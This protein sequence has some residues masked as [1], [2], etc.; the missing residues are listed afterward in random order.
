MDLTDIK[1]SFEQFRDKPFRPFQEESIKWLLGSDKRFTILEAPTGSGKTLIAMAAGVANGSLTYMVH[2]KVL[3]NQVTEDFPEARSLF[4]RA[5]YSCTMDAE[6]SC[7]EC[8]HS[9]H[10]PCEYKYTCPYEVQKRVVLGARLKILNYDYFLSE[11]NY[12]GRFRDAN[13]L[14]IDEADNL[15]N[16]LINFCTLTFSQ[17]AIN[18]LG[19][20]EPAR[21]TAKSKEGIEPWRDFAQTAKYRVVSI[22]NKLD[23]EIKDMGEIKG[24]FRIKKVKERTRVKRLLEKIDLFL[25][26]VDE[27]WIFDDRGESDT[28]NTNY[29]TKYMP[30]QNYVFR[31]LWLNEDLAEEFLWKHG[32]KWVL[33]S[34][35]FLPQH[36]LTKTLGIPPNEVDYQCTPSTFP[37]ERRPIHIEPVANLTS[38]TMDAELPA[39]VQRIKEI[40]DSHPQ[41]KGLIHAV[42]YKLANQI[43]NGVQN[44]RLTTHNSSD[45]QAKLDYFVESGLPLVMVSPSMERGVNLEQ[46][47]CRFI[48][49]AKA[50]FLNLGDKIVSSR[51]YSNGTVGRDWYQATMLLTVLQGC[52]RGMRSED[53]Y[54]E[55]YILDEQF[56][57]VYNKRPLLLPEWWREA[58]TW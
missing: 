5:N 44:S 15:E 14:I 22:L 57:R 58:V 19:L 9:K 2:S 48:I 10:Y 17:Y 20:G 8:I 29:G 31:P 42:S 3:Q 41:D 12:V 36:I 35:S 52:G 49:V 16:T 26:N 28:F 18:R 47:L 4:G 39:L 37:P 24:E 21:K 32:K 55:V 11:V 50:P 25:N 40:V 6:L 54:C 33:M 27:T 53:D 38:K 45:R 1:N 43:V 46:D 23:F 51:V 13:F 7:D 30:L 56:Q 34:A